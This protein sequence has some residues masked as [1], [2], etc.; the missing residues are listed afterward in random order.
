MSRFLTSPLL[1]RLTTSYPGVEFRVSP[2][3]RR[4]PVLKATYINGRVKAVCVRNKEKEQILKM[5][6][7]LVGNSGKRNERIKGKKVLSE[8]ESV[9]GVWSP[10]HGGIKDI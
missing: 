8:N 9:R 1:N 2:K 3:P 10:M 4:H 6:E 7:F 5:A